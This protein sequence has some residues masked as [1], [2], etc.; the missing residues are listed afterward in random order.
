M[1]I[2]EQLLTV[3]IGD[4]PARAGN[5]FDLTL[6]VGR[7]IMFT[8]GLDTPVGKHQF[9]TFQTRFEFS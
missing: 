7:C 6:T 5:V 4:L 9:V 1:S 8:H 3:L 2:F